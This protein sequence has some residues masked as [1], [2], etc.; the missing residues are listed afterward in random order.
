MKLNVELIN[1]VTEYGS[2]FNVLWHRTI[3]ETDMA[4]WWGLLVHNVHGSENPRDDKTHSWPV[5]K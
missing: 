5:A 4:L 1:R 3:M 2:G